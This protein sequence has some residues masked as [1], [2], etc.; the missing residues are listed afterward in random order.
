[1]L[2]LLHKRWW[3]RNQF[4]FH[5]C[6][7]CLSVAFIFLNLSSTSSCE[8]QIFLSAPNQE[9]VIFL[10]YIFQSFKIYCVNCIVGGHFIN[11][12]FYKYVDNID[13]KNGLQMGYL[14]VFVEKLQR[15]WNWEKSIDFDKNLVYHSYIQGLD[16]LKS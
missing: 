5:I 6:R 9:S 11:H 16:L 4:S 8:W 12:Q 7:L 15:F 3:W 2:F 1:M 10:F 14:S 13:Y